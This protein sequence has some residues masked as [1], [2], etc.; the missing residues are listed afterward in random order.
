VA[1]LPQVVGEGP[2]AVGQSLNVVVEH[3]I[4]HLIA[5]R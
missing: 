2:D 1:G 4:G 5:S 3:D